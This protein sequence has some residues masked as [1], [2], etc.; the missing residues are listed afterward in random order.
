MPVHEESLFDHAASQFDEFISK[1]SEPFA[2]FIC[3]VDFFDRD[4]DSGEVSAL[5]SQHMTG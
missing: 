2:V 1:L 5:E 4:G 3:T